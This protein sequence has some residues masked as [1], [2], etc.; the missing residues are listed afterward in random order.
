M[1]AIP[2]ESSTMGH[3]FGVVCAASFHVVLHTLVLGVY[4][5]TVPLASGTPLPLMNCCSPFGSRV[6]ACTVQAHRSANT[7]KVR[8]HHRSNERGLTAPAALSLA[9]LLPPLIIEVLR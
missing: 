7:A 6:A 4:M 8:A 5:N 1:R 9:C 2:F 3:A